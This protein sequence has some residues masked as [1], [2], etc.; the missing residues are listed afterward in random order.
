MKYLLLV[1]LATLSSNAIATPPEILH[2][3]AYP[4]REEADKPWYIAQKE[5]VATWVFIDH[6]NNPD[7]KAMCNQGILNQDKFRKLHLRIINDRINSFEKM[8]KLM[9]MDEN[10]INRAKAIIEHEKSKLI[11]L[12]NFFYGRDCST[13]HKVTDLEILLDGLYRGGMFPY[14]IE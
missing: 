12:G 13:S 8:I 14:Y 1:A 3:W 11:K 10:H 5:L 7:P 4:S 6:K 9:E 2:V